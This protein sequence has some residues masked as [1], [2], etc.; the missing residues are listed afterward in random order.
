M[1]GVTQSLLALAACTLIAACT[2]RPQMCDGP[3]ACGAK[4]AC[5]ANRCQAEGATPALAKSRRFVLEPTD[6][7]FIARKSNAEAGSL[8]RVFT[9]GQK[10]AGPAALLLQ[11]V[12]PILDDADVIEAYVLLDRVDDFAWEADRVGLHAER[13][14][15]AWSGR[16][17]SWGTGPPLDDVNAPSL[18]LRDGA[19]RRVRVDVASI[20]RHWREP[21]GRDHGI[22]IVADHFNRA[23]ASFAAIP[24]TAALPGDPGP[25][26]L[27]AALGPRL[28]LYV[29]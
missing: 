7:A 23:G 13:V 3:T 14:T 2:V 1:T 25:S 17:A 27:T 10:D 26:P 12:A 22:A 18:F 6:V 16:T 11:W 28:E 20:V 21:G 9:V 5:V 29:K 15:G 19:P 8:P 24:T 4:S